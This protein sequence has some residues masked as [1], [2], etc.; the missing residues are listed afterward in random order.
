MMSGNDL[1]AMA[2]KSGFS[3]YQE[4]F[5]RFYVPMGEVTMDVFKTIIVYLE[6]GYAMTVGDG[7]TYV[8]FNIENDCDERKRVISSC[9]NKLKQLL[10]QKCNVQFFTKITVEQYLSMQDYQNAIDYVLKY[11][12]LDDNQIDYCAISLVC[13][14]GSFKF[15]ELEGMRSM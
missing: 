2:E 9:K 6:N 5:G 15:V 14:E 11:F 3:A 1:R 8:I 13:Q 12:S 7:N 10:I 4:T